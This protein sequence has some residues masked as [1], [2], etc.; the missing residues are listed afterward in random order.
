MGFLTKLKL[1]RDD[2]GYVTNEI[3]WASLEQSLKVK[4]DIGVEKTLA[5]PSFA[6]RFKITVSPGGVVWC[7]HGSTP[8]A[9]ATT[10]FVNETSEQNPI[11]RSVFDASGTRISTLRFLSETDDAF[12]QVIFYK[13]DDADLSK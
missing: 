2:A 1:G 3:P 9:I 5:V 12:V 11:I 6:F 10:N 7:G 4:L 13:R 8:L